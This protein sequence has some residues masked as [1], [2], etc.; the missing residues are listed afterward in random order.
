[1]R[2]LFASLLSMG[3]ILL[4]A[5]FFAPKAPAQLPQR[6]QPA[7]TAPATPNPATSA[8]ASTSAAPAPGI[9]KPTGSTVTSAA[10]LPVIP[11]LAATQER[12]I[13]IEN[14]LY[15]VEISNRGAVV[16]SWQLKKYMDDAKPPRVLDVV[17][18]K[19]AEQVGGWPFS[20]VLDDPELQTAANAGLYQMTPAAAEVAS[21]TD[22]TFFWSDG[23]L[24]ITKHFHFE[25]S[26]VAHVEV[27]AKK[28]GA[29]ITAGIAWLG[30]F[31]DLT[32]ANPANWDSVQTYY[33]EAERFRHS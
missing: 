4:W 23:H 5:R 10:P 26:Y 24:E 28:D 19:A 17:H 25:Q 13:V 7:Q 1:M 20:V 3:V 29:P 12:T 6:N 16:K 31:G 2:I 18:P 21:P 30:G 8:P 15:R 9:G 32:V 33:S 27:S 11:A 14:D 22:A